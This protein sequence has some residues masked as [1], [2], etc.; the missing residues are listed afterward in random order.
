MTAQVLLYISGA[1]FL[2]FLLVSLDLSRIIRKQSGRWEEARTEE[3]DETSPLMDTQVERP[4]P[5]MEVVAPGG[6]EVLTTLKLP[7][8]PEIRDH[9]LTHTDWDG[10]VSGALLKYF[11]PLATVSVT[12]APGLRRSLRDLARTGDKPNRLFI[13]DVGVE[14]RYLPDIESALIDLARAGV[15]IY[16]YD[17][18]PWSPQSI[19]TIKADCADLIVDDHYKQAGEIVKRRVIGEDPYAEKLLRLL[20][21]RLQPEE[22]EWGRDWG[23]LITATQNSGSRD[24]I[25]ELI[26][27]LAADQ[28]FSVLDRFRINRLEQ[29]EKIYKEF[30]KKKHR[31]ERTASGRRFLVVD[32][33][34]FRMEPDDQGQMK[35][36]FAR[37]NPPASIAHDID[38]H[39]NPDFYILVLKNDRLSIRSGRNRGFTIEPLQGLTEIKGNPIR[40]AGHKYAAGVYLTVGFKSKLRLL[41]DWS[42]PEE[43]EDFIE[44]VK[45]RA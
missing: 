19:D 22:E 20:T 44:E 28:S 1:A 9:I 5:E 11:S 43:I 7:R 4:V 45:S 29:E 14:S 38:L 35:R 27:S 30:A 32:L 3:E 12:S 40:V 23:R 25:A 31:E 34:V 18:H 15:K 2:L 13:A 37:H 36:R 6:A 39:H 42:M 10:I 26:G 21:N 16:W 24:E 17:H 8:A 33:R 41:W